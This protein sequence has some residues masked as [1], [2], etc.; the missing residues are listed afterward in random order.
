M[1]TLFPQGF[2]EVEHG[3][4]VELIA[5]TD[6]GGEERMWSA[7]GA[8][9]GRDVAEGWEDRWREFHRPVRA[10]PLWIGQPW[11]QRP[12][13]AVAV[14]I[15][16]GRAFGTGAH[17]TTRLCVELLAAMPRGSVL[18]LGCGS[19]VLSIAAAKLGFS[20]VVSLDKEEAA[21]EATLRNAAANDVVVDARCADALTEEL[22]PT[23]VTLANITLEIVAAAA[24]RLQ[25]RSLIASGYLLSDPEELAGYR[26]LERITEE[27]WAADRYERAILESRPSSITR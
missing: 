20:P 4:G 26:H 5:Y 24:P 8:A 16:P 9:R 7:F 3:D 21:I 14:V 15:E 6:S 19:G 18:D 11:Q 23:D 1:I 17:P 10:G 13:D 12:D 2:E 25:S 27:G 22:P